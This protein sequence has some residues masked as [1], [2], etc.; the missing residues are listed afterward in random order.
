MQG[1]RKDMECCLGS[2]QAH[3]AI[4]PNITRSFLVQMN[5][6]HLLII[7]NEWVV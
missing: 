6:A 3:F 1:I 5:R 4:I 7:Y 2:F